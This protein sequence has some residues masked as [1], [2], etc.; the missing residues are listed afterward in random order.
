M[1]YADF[2]RSVVEAREIVAS[3]PEA[4]NQRRDALQNLRAN[5]QAIGDYGSLGMLTL[6]EV[7]AAK[8]HHRRALFGIGSYYRLPKYTTFWPRLKSAGQLVRY[9]ISGF[10]WGHGERPLNTLLS[11][12]FFLLA[13]S[14]INFWAVLDH[15]S[16]SATGY[17][18]EIVRYDAE[19]FLD[20]QPNSAFGGFLWVDYAVATTRYVYVGIFVSI[21]FKS[22]SNR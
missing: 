20:L 3:L 18:V 10:V 2:E 9:T 8:E 1:A 22:I 16:W 7:A 13:L 4:P 15:Q 12:A 19:L 14:F 11:L 6:Q 17:G 21:L 5:A